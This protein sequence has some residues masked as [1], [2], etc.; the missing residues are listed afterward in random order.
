MQLQA[1]QG[2]STGAYSDPRNSGS[3]QPDRPAFTVPPFLVQWLA[4]RTGWCFAIQQFFSHLWNPGSF[5]CWVLQQGHLQTAEQVQGCVSNLLLTTSLIP[6]SASI[7]KRMLRRL[8]PCH[9][10]HATHFTELCLGSCQVDLFSQVENCSLFF[11]NTQPKC[12]P[13]RR[14]TVE[15]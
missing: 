2:W 12:S 5:V 6:L 15:L 10:L 8:F 13:V 3:M 11:P 7:E 9:P 4:E 14:Q 1:H